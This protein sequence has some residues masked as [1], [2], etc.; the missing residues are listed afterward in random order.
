MALIISIRMPF[1]PNLVSKPNTQRKMWFLTCANWAHSKILAYRQKLQ[2]YSPSA[3]ECECSI[4]DET[5]RSSGNRTCKDILSILADIF[6]FQQ[7]K[8]LGS[9]ELH[10]HAFAQCYVHF[11]PT[12]TVPFAAIWRWAP[13]SEWQAGKPIL[14]Q[15]LFPLQCSKM[16]I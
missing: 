4:Y 1:Q 3:G 12:V 11:N 5:E 13:C 15:A 8:L 7:Q 14:P 9:E 10:L 16:T 2:L 6:P